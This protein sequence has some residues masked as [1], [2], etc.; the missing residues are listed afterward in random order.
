MPFVEDIAKQLD[1]AWVKAFVLII[2]I[3]VVVHWL[4]MFVMGVM[5]KERYL[6]DGTVQTNTPFT[7]GAT[8]RVLSQLPTATNQS[9]REWISNS[10]IKELIPGVVSSGAGKE[11][12]VSVRAD[13]NFF[14]IGDELSAYQSESSAGLR[15]DAAS[16]PSGSGSEHYSSSPASQVETIALAQMLGTYPRSASAY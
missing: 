10:E 4:L 2:V 11:R 5:K 6:G 9:D 12:L 8:M 13:P 7:S 15:Q 3:L 1:K 14:E 16:D